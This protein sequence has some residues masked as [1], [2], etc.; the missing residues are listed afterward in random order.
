M[1]KLPHPFH[2]S[3]FDERGFELECP[4]MIC[5]GHQ[6]PAVRQRSRVDRSAELVEKLTA[7]KAPW[8]FY[9]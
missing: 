2:F 7:R 9:Q 3:L 8:C 4:V 6:V 1:A 5:G